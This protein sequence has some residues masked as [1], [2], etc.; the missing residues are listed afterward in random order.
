M[1]R[2]RCKMICDRRSQIQQR[3]GALDSSTDGAQQ[4]YGEGSGLPMLLQSDNL[5]LEIP[6]VG[7]IWFKW[8][9]IVC[10]KALIGQPYTLGD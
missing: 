4:H 1:R 2:R 3:Q 10:D 7:W 9:S 5:S 8:Y 6:F